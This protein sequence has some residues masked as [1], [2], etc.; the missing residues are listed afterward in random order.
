MVVLRAV[1]LEG[2]RRGPL[3]QKNDGKPRNATLAGRLSHCAIELAR[4]CVGRG[5]VAL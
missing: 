5:V 4:L 3:G 1:M 2:H